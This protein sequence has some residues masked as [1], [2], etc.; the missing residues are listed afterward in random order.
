MP[1]LIEGQVFAFPL[2]PLKQLAHSQNFFD[3]HKRVAE[4][5]KKNFQPL[6]DH[7]RYF[8]NHTKREIQDKV[9]Q[10][11]ALANPTTCGCFPAV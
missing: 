4:Q 7:D 10:I 2:N 9:D 11:A 1:A 6:N 8:L 5:K 3:E